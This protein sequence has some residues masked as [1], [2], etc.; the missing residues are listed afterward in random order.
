[1]VGK[2]TGFILMCAVLFGSG[3]PVFALERYDVVLKNGRILDGSG[4]PWFIGDVAIRGDRIAAV[5]T[6]GEYRAR[7]EVDISGLYLAPGFMDP[8]SH[9]A[10]ALT[11]KDR[12]DAKAL[13]AQGVTTVFLNPDGGGATPNLIEQQKDLLKD[14]LGVNV[15]QFIPHGTIR[16]KVM[17]MA[18]RL[19]TEGEL[20]QMREW[21][22]RGMQAGGVGLSSGPFYPPGSYADARE[23]VELA[24]V[25]ASDG[26]VYSSHIRD[27]ADYGVGVVAAVDE[28]IQVSREANLPAI[29]THIKVQAPARGGYASAVAY[30]IDQARQ[31]G[32]QV[33][34]DQ[35][36]YTASS[37]SLPAVMLPRWA[38]AGGTGAIVERLNDADAMARIYPAMEKNLARVG[39]PETIMISSFPANT[40]LEGRFLSDLAAEWQLLPVDAALKLF[41]MGSDE[42]K[43][44]VG[45]VSFCMRDEDVHTLMKQSWTMTS[46][47]GGYPEW[48]KGKPHPRA[49]GAYPR[50]LRK[51]VLEDKI[52]ELPHA[53]RSMTSLTAQVFSL[54]DR[55][56]VRAG[57]IADIVVF[58]L[59]KVR[60]RATYT[61][62]Y[63]M[64]EGMVH[65]F[66]N[67]KGAITDGQFT[68]ELAG[69]L[70]RGQ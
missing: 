65:V 64:A 66:V 17:G 28:A 14:G 44:A 6:L 22:R 35:Y 31:Q 52:I 20:E 4:N 39:G 30:H 42:Q 8:H 21:V 50:K 37:T 16:E 56:V 59:K 33:Y 69:R 9:A 62:P 41:T 48:G 49:F 67:G 57:A 15:V 7:Q 23:L 24:K 2:L 46:S 55:G 25:A 70:V 1:M 63:Q 60:D 32:L 47:D 18:D 51:Y 40:N 34:A 38:M 11:S 61:E 5:G 58:D 68:G 27:E 13:L 19:A 45:I 3:T 10:G 29:I 53:I 54:P 43:L 36:P 26:G 12:S